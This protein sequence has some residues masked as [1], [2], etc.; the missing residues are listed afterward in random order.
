M[1][2]SRV[3]AAGYGAVHDVA[4]DI[5]DRQRSVEDCAQHAV[6]RNA[7]SPRAAIAIAFDDIKK[8]RSK[9]RF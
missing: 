7:A 3:K 8:R 5:S 9:R 6:N 1:R 2:S 4:I